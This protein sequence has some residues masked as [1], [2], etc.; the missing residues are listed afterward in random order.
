MTSQGAVHIQVRDFMLSDVA[1]AGRNKKIPYN[2]S[3]RLSR[4]ELI[5][6]CCFWR[7]A[8]ERKQ[9][10]QPD[11]PVEW[12]SPLLK[13]T[14]IITVEQV[15]SYPLLGRMKGGIKWS[16]LLL[17]AEVQRKSA[18]RM[19]CVFDTFC[20]LLLALCHT[21]QW[22]GRILSQLAVVTEF[23][24]SCRDSSPDFSTATLLFTRSDLGLS[25]LEMVSHE[26]S[27][28]TST[29]STKAVAD[30]FYNVALILKVLLTF[31][32]EFLFC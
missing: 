14:F 32:L 29:K 23:C 5:L 7:Q 26:R 8:F 31:H 12:Q 28:G 19:L 3:K 20:V 25:L 1:T 16:H 2:L 30:L 27:C 6:C 15:H 4:R 10:W 17:T 22:Q 11:K 18:C 24:I 13:Q 9:C 21:S